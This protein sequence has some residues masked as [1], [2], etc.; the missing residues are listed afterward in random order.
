MSII[1]SITTGV[2][3]LRKYNFSYKNNSSF[4]IIVFIFSIMIGGI[5]INISGLDKAWLLHGP[6]NNT[7]GHRLQKNYIQHSYN[8]KMNL[9]R[10]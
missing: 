1:I 10:Y 2:I 3:L 8:C 5:I 7:I 6:I 4:V 9:K